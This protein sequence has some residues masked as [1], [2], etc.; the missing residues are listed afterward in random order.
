V[1]K[2]AKNEC[3]TELQRGTIHT[4]NIFLLSQAAGTHNIFGFAGNLSVIFTPIYGKRLP[5]RANLLI[6]SGD[7]PSCNPTTPQQGLI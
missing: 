1:H 7:Q 4:Q 3:L 6:F 2:N 5:A